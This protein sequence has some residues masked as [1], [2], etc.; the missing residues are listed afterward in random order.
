MMYYPKLNKKID[1]FKESKYGEG[2][3]FD[4]KFLSKTEFID[5]KERI[6]DYDFY[7]TIFMRLNRNF[8]VIIHANI[9]RAD[10]KISGVLGSIHPLAIG[11]GGFYFHHNENICFSHTKEDYSSTID[12]KKY[13]YRTTFRYN[14]AIELEICSIN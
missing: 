4:G 9:Y 7:K 3:I 1:S 10:N 13:K 2:I 8:L 12:G 14:D 6:K 11:D 5:F